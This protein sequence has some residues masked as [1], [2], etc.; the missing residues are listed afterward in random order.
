M[1]IDSARLHAEESRNCFS[2]GELSIFGGLWLVLGLFGGAL[3][4]LWLLPRNL[5]LVLLAYASLTTLR[6]LAERTRGAGGLLAAGGLHMIR[7][8]AGAVAIGLSF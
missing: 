6:D 3:A 7:L 2:T 1:R 8:L 4:S 5:W